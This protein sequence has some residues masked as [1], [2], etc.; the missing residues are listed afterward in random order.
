MHMI[1]LMNWRGQSQQT[2]HTSG[3]DEQ[4]ILGD[5]IQVQLAVEGH[6]RRTTID[7]LE[8]QH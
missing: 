5:K 7:T 2:S 4:S 3:R 1:R 8:R 6:Q